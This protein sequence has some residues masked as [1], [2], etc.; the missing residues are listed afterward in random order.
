MNKKFARLS[1]TDL[2]HCV[3]RLPDEVKAAVHTQKRR[4]VIAG[5][6]IRSVIAGEK[7]SDVD[8]FVDQRARAQ[9]VAV[10]IAGPEG[11]VSE[12]QN[13]LTI[14]GRIPVQII[15]RWTFDSPQ[16]VVASF[17][18][19]IARAAIWF[20]G[21]RWHSAVDTRYYADL[22]A[23]RLVYMCP[24]RNEDAGGSM[25]RVLKFYKRGYVIPVDSLGAVMARMSAA[26]SPDA[27]RGRGASR[28]RRIAS[29]LTA[30]LHEVDPQVDPDHIAHLPAESANRVAARR[31]GKSGEPTWRKSARLESSAARRRQSS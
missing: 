21:K 22:A 3:H 12:T 25:L 11:R 17:D 2:L 7:I 14:A 20:D 23:K 29:E 15:T 1:E 16:A 18:F 8:L 10:Q 9:A 24:I 27:L 31:A 6:F 28:E 4:L 19:T 5:G 13:A 30:L 26:L